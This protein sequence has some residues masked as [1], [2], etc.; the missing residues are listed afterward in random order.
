MRQ[1]TA[2]TKNVIE[3]TFTKQLEDLD[4]TDNISLLSHSY[5]NAKEKLCCV[6]EK[7]EKTGLQINTRKTDVM[8]VNNKKQDLPGLHQES[9]KEV[10]KFVYL[11][12]VVSKDRG[13]TDE[14]I[15]CQINK[16]RQAFNTLRPI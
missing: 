3:W 16:A 15:K 14:D 9:I 8:R 4:Y 6:A 10:D 13:G 5:Q 11:G 2:D 1:A 7:A 12:S